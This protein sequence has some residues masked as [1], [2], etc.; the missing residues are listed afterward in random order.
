MT[1]TRPQNGP[2]PNAT[3]RATL[4]AYGCTYSMIIGVSSVMP[5]MVCF[6]PAF[7]LIGVV[8][9]IAGAALH[10]FG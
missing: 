7:L 2:S 9:I 4:L 1:D 3:R 5:L 10:L 8:P 6:L